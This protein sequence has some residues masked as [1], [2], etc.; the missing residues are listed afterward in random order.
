MTN[1]AVMQAWAVKQRPNGRARW[2]QIGRV[3]PHAQGAGLTVVL[4]ALPP[5][6]D[7]RIVL[8]EN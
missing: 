3:Y 4:D 7:G 8:L 5:K 2:S 1:D 6:F